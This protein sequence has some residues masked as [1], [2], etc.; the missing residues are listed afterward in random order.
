MQNSRNL[1]LS[2]ICLIAMWHVAAGTGR[3]DQA[4]AEKEIRAAAASFVESFKKRDAAAIAAQW[5]NDGIYVNEEGERFAG[6]ESIQAEYQT[7]FDNSPDDLEL[8]LEIDSI[9]LINPQTAIEE[10]RAA[11]TPQPPGE[12]RVMSRYTAIHVQ[13]DGRWLMSDVHDTLV[14]L[15]PDLGQ[16]KDLNWLVGDWS[17][18]NQD[19]KLEVTVRWIENDQFL[20]RSY[21]ATKAGKVI[22]RG[23]Q[24]IGVDPSTEQITS[25]SFGGDGSHAVGLWIPHEKGWLV[26]S[27]GV[28]KDGTETTATDILSPKDKDTLLWKSVNRSMGDTLL[29][30]TPE[31]TLKRK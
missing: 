3:A 10:G 30:D 8:R 13:Q 22:S 25:W 27:N 31:V 28:M 16:L 19:A 20:A 11:L 14:E 2:V 4:A 12:V 21:S 18:S 23:L 24:I 9:R 17:S 26:D 7:L 5:T 6:R 1:S 29:P 15:P